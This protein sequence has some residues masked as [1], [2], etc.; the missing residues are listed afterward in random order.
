MMPIMGHWL[1]K[2]STG[3]THREIQQ[4]N[5][6][7]NIK[8]MSVPYKTTKN[9]FVVKENVQ[10][11]VKKMQNSDNYTNMPCH[12]QEYTLLANEVRKVERGKVRSLTLTV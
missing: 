4:V 8:I 2:R 11:N 7:M 6:E 10:T 9:Y 3:N 1:K 5:E 12:F